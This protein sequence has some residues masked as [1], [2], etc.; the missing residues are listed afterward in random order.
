LYNGYGLENTV[1]QTVPCIHFGIKPVQ[2]EKVPKVL[3]DLFE[4]NELIFVGLSL[5]NLW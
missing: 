5:K 4:L 2:L 3:F 1:F